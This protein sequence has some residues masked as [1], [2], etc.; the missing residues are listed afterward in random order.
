MTIY[1]SNYHSTWGMRSTN[2]HQCIH[3]WAEHTD[4]IF[5]QHKTKFGWETRLGNKN[6]RYSKCRGKKTSLQ[7]R[8]WTPGKIYPSLFQEFVREVGC[9]VLDHGTDWIT[10]SFPCG[11][12]W[13]PPSSTFETQPDKRDRTHERNAQVWEHTPWPGVCMCKKWKNQVRVYMRS[14]MQLSAYFF[15]S[16][17]PF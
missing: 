16:C 7:R 12:S 15:I 13:C 1:I 5:S 8:F 6:A 10:V 9:D 14:V 11:Y 17:L 4:D 3:M 2:K